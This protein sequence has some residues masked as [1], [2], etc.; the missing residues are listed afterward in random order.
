MSYRFH[1]WQSALLFTAILIV[2]L[3]FAWSTFLSWVFLIG[4]VVLIAFMV[5]K[6]YRDAEILDR[7]VPP[8]A[9]PPSAQACLAD[10]CYRYELPFIGRIASRFLDDE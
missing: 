10:W 1:A 6:A 8:L 2:H 4:D 9:R 7:Y 3:I 5:L